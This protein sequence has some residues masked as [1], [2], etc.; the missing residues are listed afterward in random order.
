V[1]RR[2]HAVQPRDVAYE[3][4][5][6]ARASGLYEEILKLGRRMGL[7]NTILPCPGGWPKLR[8]DKGGWNGQRGSVE[9]A[10]RCARLPDGRS[11]PPSG[12]STTVSWL[13]PAGR[14]GKMRLRRRG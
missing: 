8:S 14:L 5:E 6:G 12:P 9:Q 7:K 2:A 10:L 4:G 11:R 1:G 3:A 13:L